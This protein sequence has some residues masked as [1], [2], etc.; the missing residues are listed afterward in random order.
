[1][2]SE[3]LANI[4]KLQRDPSFTIRDQSEVFASSSTTNEITKTVDSLAYID[5]QDECNPSIVNS[6]HQYDSGNS[7]GN[8]NETNNSAIKRPLSA[9]S[10][11]S[12]SDKGYSQPSSSTFRRINWNKISK[13]GSD[14]V[15][16]MKRTRTRINSMYHSNWTEVTLKRKRMRV[17]STI[18]YLIIVVSIAVVL[19]WYYWF[20]WNPPCINLPWKHTNCSEE[21]RITICVFVHNPLFWFDH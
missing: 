17:I 3:S 18:V 4:T 16:S 8:G 1:M 7:N 9:E 19:T 10:T 5:G 2:D 14:Q 15:N 20:I 12:I 13:D 6:S 11:V 21:V